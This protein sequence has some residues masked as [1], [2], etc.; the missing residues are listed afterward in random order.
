MRKAADMMQVPA[1]FLG[2]GM[3]TYTAALLS[4]TSTP[5][6]S[7][8]PQALA[9]QFGTSAMATAAATLSLGSR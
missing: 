6:W 4:S 2:A 1:A 8:A 5:V 9:V 7:A 3:S